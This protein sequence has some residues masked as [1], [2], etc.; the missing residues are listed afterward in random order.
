MFKLRLISFVI[1]TMLIA[2][3]S[4][5]VYAIQYDIIK[6]P[7]ADIKSSTGYFRTVPNF[8]LAFENARS[9]D[10]TVRTDKKK[11]IVPQNFLSLTKI[12]QIQWI[13]NSER[14]ARG[15]IVNYPNTPRLNTISQSYAKLISDTGQ[16]SHNING[17]SPWTRMD[18]DTVLKS[19]KESSYLYG[20]SIFKGW[21]N[22]PTSTIMWHLYS[23]YGFIYDDAGSNWGHRK[24]LLSNFN[25]NHRLPDNK[26]GLLG[27][28]LVET[29]KQGNI[30]ES[31]VVINSIDPNPACPL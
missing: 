16:F 29:I 20:E 30:K 7:S 9:K 2:T 24:H 19:C 6:N 26:E 18:S 14:E 28:G 8:V 11:I 17:T 10:P 22:S 5:N 21:S 15:L 27:I 3:L 1:I 13:L 12:N 31:V 4:T 23:I 25:N